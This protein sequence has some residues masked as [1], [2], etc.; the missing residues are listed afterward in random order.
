MFWR[1]Y[2]STSFGLHMISLSN[3]EIYVYLAVTHYWPFS[4]PTFGKIKYYLAIE[5]IGITLLFWCSTASFA[6][7]LS[8]FGLQSCSEFC[9]ERRLSGWSLISKNLNITLLTFA[10]TPKTVRI[11]IWGP[12]DCSFLPQLNCS[13]QSYDCTLSPIGLKNM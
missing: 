11:I 4:M 7:S 2:Y 10:Y 12:R 3:V 6:F 5:T 1:E 13:I 9:L 8:V